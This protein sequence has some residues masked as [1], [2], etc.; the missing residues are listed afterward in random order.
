MAFT[1]V[2]VEEDPADIFVVATNNV[3]NKD[4]SIGIF[5]DNCGGLNGAGDLEM[6]VNVRP[7]DEVRQRQMR[8][9]DVGGHT[10][11]PKQE[12]DLHCMILDADGIEQPH[13]ITL[14]HYGQWSR[15]KTIISQVK[16]ETRTITMPNGE[17]LRTHQYDSINN[18][19]NRQGVEKSRSA[20]R[21]ADCCG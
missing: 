2:L 13:V 18:C 20:A 1:T 10:Y 11:V 8:L 5:F 6:L 14:A 3:V 16:C 7:I 9:E 15:N 21:V 12:G 4:Y 17:M 19:I